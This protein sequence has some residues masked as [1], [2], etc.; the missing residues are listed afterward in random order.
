M[1]EYHQNY[2]LKNQEKIKAQNS[3]YQAEHKAE[4]SAR[5]KA[6]K[7]TRLTKGELYQINQELSQAAKDVLDAWDTHSGNNFEMLYLGIQ[8]LNK[9]LICNGFRKAN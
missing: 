4:R 5:E 7:H 3:L 8:K 9:V 6:Y 2:Y 1:S